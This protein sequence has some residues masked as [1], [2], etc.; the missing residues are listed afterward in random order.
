MLEI[1][2]SLG[3]GTNFSG[4]L[5]TLGHR[6]LSLRFSSVL[7]DGGLKWARC[8]FVFEEFLFR[9]LRETVTDLAPI[10]LSSIN[11]KKGGYESPL[12]VWVDPFYLTHLTPPVLQTVIL[13][14]L[15]PNALGKET[16]LKCKCTSHFLWLPRHLLLAQGHVGPLGSHLGRW[17]SLS[18]SYASSL[19][20]VK[21]EAQESGP[22]EGPIPHSD[23]SD[24]FNDAGN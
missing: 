24:I 18:A 3:A 20:T 9:G 8:I 12:G 11:H 23:L 2:W 16:G 14:L 4:L 6:N 13:L 15:T 22:R 1:D 5:S 10:T 21:L 19:G 7:Q 17:Q